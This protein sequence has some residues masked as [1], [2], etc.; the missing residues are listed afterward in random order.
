[1]DL[2]TNQGIKVLRAGTSWHGG[3]HEWSLPTR[4]GDEEWT[5]GEWTPRVAPSVCS[6]GW[7][8]TTEPGR[9]WSEDAGVTAYLAEWDGALARREGDEKFAV[10]RC[11]LL[12]ELTADELATFNVF[13]S[14]IHEVRAGSAWA[15]GSATVT[16]YDSATV[17][18]Y[19]SATVTAYDS[20]TVRAYDSA[21]VRADDSATVTATG[22]ATVTATGSA[23]VT[24]TGSATV[25]AYGSATVTAYDSATVTAYDSATVTATGSAKAHAAG[26]SVATV[27]DIGVVVTRADQ[28]VIVDRRGALPRTVCKRGGL[29]GWRYADGEWVLSARVS[30]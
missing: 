22:S 3:A 14:G 11:R 17:R 6:Q 23:T 20:A 21:T 24:A 18:A 7:H 26:Q 29:D 4:A 10:E 1:M 5:P 15:T 28:G 9:W 19:D 27:C 25:R 13:L 8:L 16:A 2:A 12:R 30:A